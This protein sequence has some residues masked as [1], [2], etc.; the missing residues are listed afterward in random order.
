MR[1]WLSGFKLA[2]W[3]L[4][5]CNV[6]LVSKEREIFVLGLFVVGMAFDAD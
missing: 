4:V 1:S 3:D 6:I 5:P 2:F